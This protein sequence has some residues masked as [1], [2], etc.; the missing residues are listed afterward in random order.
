MNII[1]DDLQQWL[2][3]IEGLTKRG[4]IFNATYWNFEIELTGGF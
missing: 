4:L 3:T 2:N 1:C